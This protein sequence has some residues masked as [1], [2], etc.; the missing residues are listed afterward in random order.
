MILYICKIKIWGGQSMEMNEIQK[1]GVI[2]LAI[3][4]IMIAMIFFV[5]MKNNIIN[6]SNTN[7]S[8][9]QFEN[10]QIDPN[11]DYIKLINTYMTAIKQK[12][13]EKIISTLPSFEEK[14]E[15]SVTEFII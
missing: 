1:K 6:K 13:A 10:V 12:N 4:V 15:K 7:N 3:G 11:A 5:K 8:S 9:A 14:N 2:L